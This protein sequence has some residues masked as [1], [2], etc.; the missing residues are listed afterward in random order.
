MKF[1]I[2]L[3][4]P[5][6][7]LSCANLAADRWDEKEEEPEVETQSEEPEVPAPAPELRQ[8]V[9]IDDLKLADPVST[10]DLMKDDDKRTVSG[11]A[12]VN[13]PTPSSDSAIDVKPTISSPSEED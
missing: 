11:P 4:I 10:S 8:D 1:L 3:P 7:L 5:F 6:L 2:L 13:M 9:N 12:P